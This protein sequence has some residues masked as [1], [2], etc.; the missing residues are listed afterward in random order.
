[1]YAEIIARIVLAAKN[2]KTVLT[3][4]VGRITAT[5]AQVGPGRVPGSLASARSPPRSVS[6]G[7]RAPRIGATRSAAAP[8]PFDRN[9]DFPDRARA[10]LG[11]RE[12]A[13]L[14]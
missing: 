10:R 7:R 12:V 6:R 13:L 3:H 14:G 8:D 11:Q 1:M 2:S 4:L 9:R 5:A